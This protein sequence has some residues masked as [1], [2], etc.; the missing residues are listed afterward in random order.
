MDTMNEQDNSLYPLKYSVGSLPQ[1]TEVF[2][3]RMKFSGFV[4]HVNVWLSI[5]LVFQI[6]SINAY[7]WGSYLAGFLWE[8]ENWNFV[9]NDFMQIFLKLYV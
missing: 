7:I 5:T 9:E 8:C 4:D 1:N 6:S 3:N 2:P